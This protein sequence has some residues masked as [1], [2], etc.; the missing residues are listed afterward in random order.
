MLARSEPIIYK[1][2]QITWHCVILMSLSIYKY[3]LVQIKCLFKPSLSHRID[4]LNMRIIDAGVLLPWSC[5]WSRCISLSLS[6]TWSTT[7]LTSDSRLRMSFVSTT[8]N[9]F[10]TSKLRINFWGVQFSQFS[11][12]TS[13]LEPLEKFSLYSTHSRG[14]YVLG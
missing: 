4:Y 3:K 11:W 6:V 10:C 9:N 2:I 12:I 13:K 7:F 5:C 8:W 14:K 1:H